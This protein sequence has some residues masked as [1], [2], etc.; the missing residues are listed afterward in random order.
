MIGPYNPQTNPAGSRNISVPIVGASRL[1]FAVTLRKQATESLS[2]RRSHRSMCNIL[3]ALSPP[4]YTSR[5]RN[6]IMAS[7]PT[8]TFHYSLLSS[9]HSC[10]WNELRLN[11][12]L[13]SFLSPCFSTPK[14][15]RSQ[16]STAYDSRAP[17][18]ESRIRIAAKTA[19]IASSPTIHLSLVTLI[20][21]LSGTRHRQP[22]SK[23]RRVLRMLPKSTQ[24][25][26]PHFL[27]RYGVL[28]SPLR[29]WGHSA[30]VAWGKGNAVLAIILSEMWGF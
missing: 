12:F 8:T 4:A 15:G 24:R 14:P 23:S 10:D 22:A 5:K 20:T 18:F 17:N 21:P 1:G 16:L 25:A 26:V 6:K 29:G 30:E 9:F 13:A 3:F 11:L 2:N 27:L 7:D 19:R 28:P